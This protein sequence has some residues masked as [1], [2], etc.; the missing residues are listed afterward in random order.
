MQNI[1]EIAAHLTPVFE[2]HPAIEAVYM[3]GSFVDGHAGPLL[4]SI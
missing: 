2:P 1:E 4:Q 3:F